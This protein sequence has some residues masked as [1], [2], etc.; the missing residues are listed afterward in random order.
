VRLSSYLRDFCK[1]TAAGP[2]SG[3]HRLLLAA[4]RKD[5]KSPAQFPVVA[6]SDVASDATR[7]RSVASALSKLTEAQRQP[8][9]DGSALRITATQRNSAEAALGT[10]MLTSPGVIQ[11]SQTPD[12]RF[13][14]TTRMRPMS[15]RR[16]SI[17]CSVR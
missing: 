8:H 10:Q 17:G 5:L 9:Q 13:L 15:L 16:D 11:A 4:A 2:R 1:R 7:A 14:P 6:D 12:R 3:R